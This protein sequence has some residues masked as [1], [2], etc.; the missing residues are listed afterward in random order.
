M[1]DNSLITPKGIGLCK[2]SRGAS[3]H[4]G[5]GLI[6]AKAGEQRIHGG[7]YLVHP[8]V[9][10]RLI[11]RAHRFTLEVV[12]VHGVDRGGRRVEGDHLRPNGIEQRRGNLVARSSVD[13]E[14]CGCV[15]WRWI[16][17]GV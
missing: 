16:P 6:I 11:Q 7:E 12:S 10:L 13:L 1:V 4:K 14:S 5:V 17:R 15:H 2:K 8:D 3:G 9:E